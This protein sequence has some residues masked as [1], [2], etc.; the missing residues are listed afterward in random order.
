M[1]SM[2]DTLGFVAAI[3]TTSAFLPQVIKAHKLKKTDELSLAMYVAFSGGVFLWIIYGIVTGS[4]PVIIANSA[5][6]ILSLYILVLK[7]RYG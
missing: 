7:R 6:L 1:V 4:W 2:I 5:T 3:L